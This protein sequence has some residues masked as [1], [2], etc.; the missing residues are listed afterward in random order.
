MVA[1]FRL[2]YTDYNS[3]MTVSRL[4]TQK[5]VQDAERMSQLERDVAE[6]KS[7]VAELKSDVAELK[8]DV[9]E[10][11]SDVVELKSGMKRLLELLDADSARSP[12]SVRNVRRRGEQR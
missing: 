3:T 10:L 8:S 11:K 9:A 1:S 4:R 7:D 5:I 6:L 12:D 2:G